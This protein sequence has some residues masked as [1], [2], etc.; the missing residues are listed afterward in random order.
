MV[1]WTIK[2]FSICVINEKET[3]SEWKMFTNREQFYTYFGQYVLFASAWAESWRRKGRGPF[4]P[5]SSYFR[6]RITS[7]SNT[8][9][10]IAFGNRCEIH[11]KSVH[12][13]S[14]CLTCLLLTRLFI[15]RPL[16]WQSENQSAT[17]LADGYIVASDHLDLVAN[18]KSWILC[19]GF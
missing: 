9:L 5:F 7:L 2:H 18:T 12:N 13:K 14:M 16:C 11:C 19:N 8:E 17:K 6:P 3:R 4:Y 10:W 1:I 15:Y